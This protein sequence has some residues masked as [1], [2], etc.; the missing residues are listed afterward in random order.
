MRRDGRVVKILANFGAGVPNGLIPAQVALPAPIGTIKVPA[1]P[2]TRL[3]IDV[4]AL[5]GRAILD[6]KSPAIPGIKFP[7][8]GP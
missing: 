2:A 4:V 6:V 8:P 3:D 7:G 5:P 1:V